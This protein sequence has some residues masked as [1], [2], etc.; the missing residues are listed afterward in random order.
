MPS[1]GQKLVGGLS[2]PQPARISLND[3]R[4]TLYTDNGAQHPTVAPGL[5]I[6][7][8]FVGGNSHV[9]KRLYSEDEYDAEN[10]NRPT[11]WSDNGTAP[12]DQVSTP[13]S[14]TC[15]MCPHN[16]WK[17]TGSTAIPPVCSDRKKTAV[18]VSGAGNSVFLLDIPP[19]SLKPFKKYMAY[20]G[21]EVHAEPE[22]V[23][24]TLTMEN[25]VL[26]FECAGHVPDGLKS[27]IKAIVDNPATDDVVN[28]HDRP[29][30][31]SLGAPTPAKAA[32]ALDKAAQ[33]GQQ[34]E[35]APRPAQFKI[36]EP[37]SSVHIDRAIPASTFDNIDVI[38]EQFTD[39]RF[40]HA[41]ADQAA[42]EAAKPMTAEQALAHNESKPAR[43]PRS[44][45]G[46]P[47]KTDQDQLTSGLSPTGNAIPAQAF[48]PE[49]QPADP[50]ARMYPK[51]DER[52]PPPPNGGFIQPESKAQFGMVEKPAP[53]PDDLHAAMLDKAFGLRIGK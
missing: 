1:L 47:R 43:K 8:I 31:L 18:M 24:T 35:A 29:H 6:Q 41:A 44:D 39:P 15:G 33:L 22:E 16:Q 52:N 34:W 26:K 4:F 50:F 32:P 17:G 20:L 5:V 48:A 11:C 9:S 25:R 21:G 19:A 45:K 12:S 3:G 51:V 14:P 37:V 13:Q 28:E 38:P 53:I 42:R 30:Q 46:V 2:A 7:V 10:H 36:T 23:I 40:A 49:P 27:G